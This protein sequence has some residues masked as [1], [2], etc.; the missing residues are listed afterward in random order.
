MFITVL[1]SD[2]PRDNALFHS[3]LKT[4]FYASNEVA[5]VI[6][7]PDYSVGLYV[8]IYVSVFQYESQWFSL[9]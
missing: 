9:S 3:T 2:S 5:H 7:W 6:I 1:L 8:D 4:V